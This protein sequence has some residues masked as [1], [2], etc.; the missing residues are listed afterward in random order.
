LASV[1]ARMDG[2]TFTAPHLELGHAVHAAAQAATEAA[3]RGT[4][5]EGAAMLALHDHQIGEN[6]LPDD[7]FLT[8][9]E[10]VHGMLGPESSI[11]FGTAGKGRTSHVEFSLYLGEDFQPVEGPSEF[12][13]YGDNGP[14]I[15]YQVR[16]D[17]LD[18][19]RVADSGGLEIID[20]KNQ[21]QML[22]TGE[23]DTSQGRFYAFTVLQHQPQFNEVT[24]RLALTRH[25]YT[26]KETYTRDD[27]RLRWAR[28]MMRA[29]RA[30]VLRAVETGNWPATVG[31]G[32]SICPV[33]VTCSEFQAHG[34]LNT[35]EIAENARERRFA[36]AEYLALKPYVADLERALRRHAD[37]IGPIPSDPG[38]MWG[39]HPKSRSVLADGVVDLLLSLAE[40]VPRE[41]LA[42]LFPGDRVGKGALLKALSW[43][44]ANGVGDV[45]DP[46]E[47]IK[48]WLV[49]E[50]YQ[51][52]GT[53]MAETVE[54]ASG[55]G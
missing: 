32:C 54:G 52:C 44:A 24:W 45:S 20:F 31:D 21:L 22:K 14:G 46:A 16:I 35:A 26:V 15:A 19:P 34:S 23:A 18:T 13:R 1:R 4:D 37:T 5:R 47:E 12:D 17:R 41:K 40:D 10:I 25:S 28:E 9:C 29:K 8:A 38:E 11:W 33:R 3:Y 50:T 42:E 53:F 7:M 6:P 27:K 51:S 39:Y 49:D 30:R 2:A 48:G 36:L 55:D 43:M